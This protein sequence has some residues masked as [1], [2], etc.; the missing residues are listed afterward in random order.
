[1]RF[2]TGAPPDLV[3]P[4]VGIGHGRVARA[5]RTRRAGAELEVDRLMA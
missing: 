3:G 4:Q 1:M 2:G 5:A